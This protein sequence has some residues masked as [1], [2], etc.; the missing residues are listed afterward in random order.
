[1]VEGFNFYL[2]S[3]HDIMIYNVKIFR[4]MS[5]ARWQ[6]SLI[7]ALRRRRQADLYEFKDILVYLVSFR[8]AK[9]T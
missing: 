3:C 8:L 6:I 9:A 1:M 5:L 2:P 7:P 4:H